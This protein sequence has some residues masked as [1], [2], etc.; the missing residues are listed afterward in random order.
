MEGVVR[1]PSAF[2]MT[3]GVAPSITATQELVVPRSMPMT[4]AMFVYPLSS[5]SAGHS[6][7]RDRHAFKAV[8]RPVVRPLVSAAAPL[9]AL[10]AHIGERH[11]AARHLRCRFR[12]AHQ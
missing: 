7:A 5:R 8:D 4:F 12:P 6:S 10:S 9:A 1:M 3:L 11:C 2:S